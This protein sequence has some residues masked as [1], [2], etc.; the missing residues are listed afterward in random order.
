[1]TYDF[2]S[3]IESCYSGI[4]NLIYYSHIPTG[5]VSLLLGLFVFAKNKTIQ[6]KILLSLSIVFALW[7]FLNLIIWISPN[8]L[9][10][11]L[12]WSL[13][14]ILS[15][16]LFLL[17]IYFTYV[18]INKKDASIKLKL[19]WL[20]LLSPMI[21]F[22]NDGLV[23][24]DIPNCEAIENPLYINYYYFI[25]V[26]SFVWIIIF[27]TVKF[28]K[29]KEAENKKQIALLGIGISLFLLS[30]FTAGYFASLIDNFE[31]E[32]YGLFGMTIFMAFLAY[33]IV[34]FKAFEIKLIAT[35]AL[36]VGLVILIGSQFFFIQT[37][38]NRILTAITLV[39]AAGVGLE[40]IRSV[41]IEIALKEE[42]ELANTNQQSLI[43]FISHQLKGFFTKSKMIFAGI[44]EDDFGPSPV[45]LKDIAKEGLK[46][47]DNAVL[48]IQNILGASNLRKGTVAY[49]F[50]QVDLSSLIK[51]LCESFSL[52]AKEKKLAFEMN[53]P[54][55]PVVVNADEKQISQ[56]FK[57]LVDNSIKYT[58]SGFVKVSLDVIKDGTKKRALFKL[59][60][61]GVGLTD[62]DNHKL[63][64]E[65]GRGVDSVK[66][67][68][69]STGYGLYIVKK[70]VE[71][72]SG[73]IWAQ[74][75]GRG[76]GSCFFVELNVI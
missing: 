75:E 50:K 56:V 54:E 37:N 72:H 11:M 36:V 6:S 14:G 28:I 35:Q 3:N 51:S 68:V 5:I 18:F 10:V 38:I 8:S 9:Y 60:D 42:L 73:R 34:R 19:I 30:F 55:T 53:I 25:G 12:F 16:L 58:P 61:S 49:E 39:I 4:S 62:D 41:K 46:S 52:E 27:S 66:V 13:F 47:D 31:L 24:F 45:V 43:H 40:I 17:C 48:M 71:T 59:A 22:I 57:N 15:V 67:N 32:Q 33:L 63:F 65:G 74:S 23:A 26:L 69:N 44:I 2:I 7:L 29:E 1:M 64:T 21:I 70:I 76:K 20:A